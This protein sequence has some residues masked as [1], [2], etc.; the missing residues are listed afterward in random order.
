MKL[1][2]PGRLPGLNEYTKANRSSCMA[3]AEMKKQYEEVIGWEI[4]KQLK[5]K[6][7]T[8]VRLTFSWYERG[9]IS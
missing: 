5:R 8:S 3:G 2:I 7:F 1:I 4:I 9:K 6:R